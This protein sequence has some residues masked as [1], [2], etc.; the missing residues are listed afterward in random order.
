MP[1]CY[2]EDCYNTSC[3]RRKS[4]KDFSQNIP[5]D[6]RSTFKLYAGSRN[7]HSSP[8]RYPVANKSISTLIGR[9]QGTCCDENFAETNVTTSTAEVKYCSIDQPEEE[10]E[11]E[12]YV[13]YCA[14]AKCSLG[15]G[16]NT[17][18]EP[19]QEDEDEV[20]SPNKYTR[21]KFLYITIQIDRSNLLKCL[22]SGLRVMFGPPLDETAV[23]TWD[24]FSRFLGWCK[25]V[26]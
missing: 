24:M 13:D 17:P 26:T 5:E 18:S 11:E 4:Y 1:R 15:E 25:V 16:A 14:Q 7:K 20:D 22:N 19:E 12:T 6:F 9:S 21:F 8:F 10:E 3:S 2:R 23:S